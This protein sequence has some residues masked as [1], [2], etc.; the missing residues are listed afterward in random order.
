[1]EDKLTTMIVNK[2]GHDL[3][4]K[5]GNRNCFVPLAVVKKRCHHA[6][7][8]CMNWTYQEFLLEEKILNDVVGKR[9]F[10]N[11]DDCCDYERITIKEADG[12]FIVDRVPRKQSNAE[13]QTASR[14]GILS[15][16]KAWLSF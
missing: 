2:T 9:L 12:K 5:V 6:M 4:M 1:M 8:L 16:L 3:I 7:E 13:E 10:V 11:S 14:Q 15:W